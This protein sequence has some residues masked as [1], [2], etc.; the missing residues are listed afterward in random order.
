VNVAIAIL[1]VLLVVGGFGRW[2]FVAKRNAEKAAVRRAENEQL[3]HAAMLRE[4]ERQS[5][6]AG[7]VR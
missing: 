4:E 3:K 5:A 6:Y 7:R 2:F 1:A